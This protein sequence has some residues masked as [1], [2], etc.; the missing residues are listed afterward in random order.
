MF[1]K[2]YTIWQFMFLRIQFYADSS[3]ISFNFW[4]I[5]IYLQNLG[6]QSTRR[7]RL[8]SDWTLENVSYHSPQNRQ[9]YSLIS[10]NIKIKKY[11]IIILPAVLYGCENWSF[12]LIKNPRLKLSYIMALRNMYGPRKDKVTGELIKLY[13]EEFYVPLPLANIILVIKL[14]KIRWSLHEACLGETRG[15]Y[16]VLVG[17]SERKSHLED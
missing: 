3:D 16:R 15:T 1:F 10:K 6:P 17:K 12:V 14:R 4:E 8:R 11:I 13:N 5:Y 2:V 7:N 9:S